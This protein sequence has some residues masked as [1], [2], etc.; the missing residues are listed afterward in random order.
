MS[1][2]K[3]GFRSYL[4]LMIVENLKNRDEI[5]FVK[6]KHKQEIIWPRLM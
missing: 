5:K 2:L 4:W 3:P 1:G 6:I